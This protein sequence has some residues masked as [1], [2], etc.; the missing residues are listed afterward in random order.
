MQPKHYS[1]LEV[2]NFSD[3]GLV[4]EF[5]STKKTN[6][7]VEN[8]G[9]SVGK[10]IILTNELKYSPTYSN[11][12]LI[13]EYDAT[14]SRYQLHIAPENYHSIIPVIDEITKWI[15]ENCETTFD[16]NLKISLSFNHRNLQTL[17]SISRMNPSRLILKFDENF[18]YER[19]PERK[20]SPYCISIKN[21]VPTKIYINEQDIETNIVQ[22]LT[23]PYNDYYGINF[24]NY[25]QG[26]LECN[27]VGGKDYAANP[28]QIKDVLEYFILKSY[29]S[30]NEEE[31]NEFEINE[32]KRLTKDFE[33]NQMS[34]WDPEIF[35][36]EF[37]DL[38]VYIDLQHSKQILKTYW[39]RIRN[40]LFEMIISGGLR[41]GQF[42][43]DSEI[44]VIQLRKC[45][46]N[47][48]V[49]KN[50]DLISCEISGILENCALVNCSVN[51]ARLYNSKLIKNNKINESYIENS[52]ANNSNKIH[53][54][55]ILNNEEVI[56]CQV[57]ES[58]IKFA[59][60]GKNIKV[61]ESTT[62]VVKQLPLPQKTDALNI[63]E[64][65]DYTW[66]KSLNPK[67]L[68]DEGFANE[69]KKIKNN[70]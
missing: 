11:S 45:K 24:K 41:E 61:D 4:F 19:F 1:I 52:T 6:F 44:G 16:T 8:I 60:P 5:Y 38:K 12:I 49:L 56:N 42:N 36:N 46:I 28:K 34:Y 25:T 14:R 48:G 33:K 23:T 43:F 54:S 47:G 67:V 7:I 18:V 3:V 21:L 13:K 22:I 70:D 40:P 58:I 32:V 35:L 30:I 59:T 37:K 55:F 17:D 65:R 39:S 27:Y 53:K 29:Q 9:R 15:N 31:L 26:I 64:I 57:T 10:N 2:L 63:E 20:N 68:K 62:L 51:K 66:I 50:T 69:F